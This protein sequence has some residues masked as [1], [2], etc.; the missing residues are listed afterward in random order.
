[1]TIALAVFDLDGT[2]VDSRRD[3]A[4]TA[5]EASNIVGG[6]IGADGRSTESELDGYLDAIGPLLDPPLAISTLAAR[7]L[8]LFRGKTEQLAHASVLYDLLCRAD[9]QHDTRRSHV[10]YELAMR[11]AHTAAALDLVPS[12][13]EL[14]A[15]DRL[16]TAM[17]QHLDA[18][19]VPRP[20]RPEPP[21]H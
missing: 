8:G 19:G 21:G 4:D 20:G 12:P 10:Y 18:I 17:L 7:G 16:R 1:M 11:L 5:N 15:I 13:T 9:A 2:L 14:T 3:L 6:V